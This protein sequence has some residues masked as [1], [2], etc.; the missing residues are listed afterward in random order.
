[1]STQ[2]V[3]MSILDLRNRLYVVSPIAEH[4]IPNPMVPTEE[5]SLDTPTEDKSV[6]ASTDE[7]CLETLKEDSI[8]DT[9]PQ[10]TGA[11]FEPLCVVRRD[12]DFSTLDMSDKHGKYCSAIHPSFACIE[13][14]LRV[15]CF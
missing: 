6:D 4:P 5:K 2:T 10:K 1:M 12:L 11:Q 15:L 14:N 7:K 9:S 13:I 3:T 8:L